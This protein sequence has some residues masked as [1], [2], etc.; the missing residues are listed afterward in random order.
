MPIEQHVTDLP[1]AGARVYAG[2][3]PMLPTFATLVAVAIFVTAGN[4][5]RARM[6]AKESLRA[7]LDAA[8]ARAP[9]SLPQQVADWSAWRFRSVIATGTFDAGHQILIDN[10]VH[11]GNVGFDVVTPLRLDDGRIVLVDRG[12]VPAGPSREVLPIVPPPSG[13]VTVRGRINLPATH[14]FELG[15][16]TPTG[17]LWQHLDVRRY[18]EATS[19]SV[20]PVVLEAT[21]PTGGDDALVREWPAPDLGIERHRIYMVQW[22]AFAAMALAFWAWFVLRPRLFQS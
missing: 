18:A 19:L 15:H 12:F 1:V 8:S 21:L 5:Q 20:L 9:A 16:E 22:Y 17:P 4:W 2:W 13:S 10:K 6:E 7:Q 3:P 11:Q 14:Y